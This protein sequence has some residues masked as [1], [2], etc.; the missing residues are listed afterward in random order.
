M[1]NQE[2]RIQKL[3][4]AK[5]NPDDLGSII[6]LSNLWDDEKSV[7]DY[8]SVEIEPGKW[9]LMSVPE[10]RSRFPER[11]ASHVQNCEFQVEWEDAEA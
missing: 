10:F 9:K 8:A 2:R 1:S 11:Y 3:E 7:P 6:V 4:A 5:N